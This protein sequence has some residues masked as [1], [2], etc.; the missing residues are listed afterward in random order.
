MIVWC[1]A[2]CVLRLGFEQA[3]FS[4]LAGVQIEEGV[5]EGPCSVR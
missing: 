1:F 3:Q 2:C 5:V 4:L